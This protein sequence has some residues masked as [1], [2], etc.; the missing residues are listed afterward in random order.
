MPDYTIG[1]GNIGNTPARDQDIE[2]N[3]IIAGIH[4]YLSAF[5]NDRTAGR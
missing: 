1:K 4:Q 3:R 2:K 5:F